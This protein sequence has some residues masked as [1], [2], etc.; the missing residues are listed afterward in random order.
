MVHWFIFSEDFR[1]FIPGSTKYFLKVIA[2]ASLKVASNR[3][4]RDK[5]PEKLALLMLFFLKRKWR[6]AKNVAYV[7]LFFF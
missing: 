7:F 2:N 1:T 6:S 3:L 5:K 4:F